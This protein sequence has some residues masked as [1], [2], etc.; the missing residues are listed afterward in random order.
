MRGYLI[1]KLP[2]STLRAP[3]HLPAIYPRTYV[4]LPEHETL[5]LTVFAGSTWQLCQC[6]GS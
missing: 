3:Y 2:T 1:V 6:E 5:C 4:S